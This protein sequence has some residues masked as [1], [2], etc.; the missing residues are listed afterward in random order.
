MKISII[1]PTHARRRQL[2]GCLESLSRLDFEPD[3]FEVIVVNDGGPEPADSWRLPHSD[4]LDLTVVHQARKGPGGARN[5]GARVASGDLL[6]FTDDDCRP[7]RAWLRELATTHERFPDRL[8]GGRTVNGL[9]GN[10]YA[11]TSQLIVGIAYAHYNPDPEH[12]RFFASNNMAVPAGLFLE[13]GGFD[14]S[15]QLASE[16][17]ELCDRW[18]HLGHKLAYAPEVVVSHHHD[19]NLVGFC[20]QHFNYGR[21]AAQFQRTRRRRRSGSLGNELRF[22]ARFLALLRGPLSKLRPLRAV[23]ILLLLGLWQIL[24][25]GGYLFALAAG[26]RSIRPRRPA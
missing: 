15:F 21:G 11:I 14:E 5:A 7:D 13:I 17:R 9:A 24:N 20:R 18:L 23:R 10:P 12:A 22:H 16:D 6:A 2:V 26:P 25:L 1:I 3:D 8:L 4:S 19:L